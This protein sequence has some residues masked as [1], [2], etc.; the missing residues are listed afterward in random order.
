MNLKPYNGQS[1]PSSNSSNHN[2]SRQKQSSLDRYHED[3]QTDDDDIDLQKILAIL[4]RR[5][6]LFASI[7]TIAMTAMTMWNLSRPTAYIGK[8]RLLVEPVTT[9]SRIA[10]SLTSETLQQF[11][12][13]TEQGGLDYISQIEVLRSR[14]L[15]EP[16]VQSIQSKYP[17][18]TYD[19]LVNQLY[20]THPE[21]SKILDFSYS[22]Q[23]PEEV[24]FV[25]NRLA[26]TYIRY[27]VE[28]RQSNLKRAINFINS[29]AQ[30]QRQE[31]SKLEG[32]LEAFRQGNNLL[33][34]ND[35]ATSLSAQA[36]QILEQQ[37]SVLI[38][39]AAAQTLYR[40]LQQQLGLSPQEA[41]VASTLS[42]AP[43]YQNLLNKLRDIESRIALESARF[44][45]N[46]PI[47]QALQDQRN[48]L[49]PLLQTEAQRILGKSSASDGANSQTLGFQ[50]SVGRELVQ[51]LVAT[52][53]QVQVLQT[54]A[55][56]IDQAVASLNQ[57]IR[58]AASV[59]RQYGQIQRDL[60]IA[61]SSLDRL[62]AARENLQLELARQAI[63]WQLMSQVDR[64]SITKISNK[65]R[66]LI[67]GGFASLFLGAAVVLLLEK[68]D[69]KLHSTTDLKSFGIPYLGTIPYSKKVKQHLSEQR[70]ALL[71]EGIELQNDVRVRTRQKY[72]DA[73]FMEAFYSLETNIRLLGSDTPIRSLAISSARD[74]EGKSTISAHLAL[75]SAVVGRK[76]LLIDADLRNPQIHKLFGIANMQ[77]LSNAIATDVDIEQ[78]IQVSSY[79]PNLYLLPAGQLPPAPGR[80]LSSN[81]MQNFA[82]S[83]N[84]TFDLVIYDTPPLQ[85]FADAK[86]IANY[87]DGILV[88]VGL[89][90]T[91]RNDLRQSLDDITKY[92]QISLLGI[93]ANGINGYTM[94][95][96][97]AYYRY[98]QK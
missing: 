23:N 55:Q 68:L 14:N 36:N 85:Y 10:N 84:Q 63:P 60:G 62:L 56:A 97:N 51:Q 80:L 88:V 34:P 28:D 8:F 41:F 31:V 78:I 89:G 1:P 22:A 61:S 65:S 19:A 81:K 52:A 27:S 96:N 72:Q 20:I 33:N 58:G 4:K 70:V 37:R 45:P 48:Q 67:M 25:L 21:D 86:L 64:A 75:A 24:Q 91:E 77:G 11:A 39:L 74:G 7:T 93:I 57:Q 90:K 49:L 13:S 3:I 44:R 16:V 98:H 17:H 95:H 9:G 43:A 5:G 82:A 38:Q 6:L 40:N 94:R 73:S 66:Q 2:S 92:G 50:G 87:L 54:Q 26:E 47:I 30:T 46:S 69:Q 18:L 15:L 79:Y 71:T 59:V 35:Q 83:F 12:S 53:N 76:V 42:E 29:Q 32:E